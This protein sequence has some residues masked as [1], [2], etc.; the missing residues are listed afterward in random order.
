MSYQTLILQIEDKIATIT[1]NRPEKLNAL[2]ACLKSELLAVLDKIEKDPTIKVIILKG[3]GEKAFIA[4]DDISEFPTRS[5]DDFRPLQEITLKIENFKKPVIAV[6]N[7]YALGD[8]CEIALACDLRIASTSAKFGFP[9]ITL[10]IIPGA[11]GT[12]RLPRVIGY[13]K[14]FEL[15]ATG[16][17]IDAKTA[18]EIGL[19]NEV[20]EPEEL[21]SVSLELAKKLAEKSGAALQAIKEALSFSKSHSIVEG[22]EKELDLVYYLK[23]TPLSKQLVAAFLHRRKKG[24]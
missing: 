3:A 8:G 20:I 11:G 15:I 24:N 23:N 4:G 7:G 16:D 18:K 5:K 19:I 17:L 13:A 1:I 9:E 14:A 21:S 10:G 2:N 12:Q 22:L 6:I